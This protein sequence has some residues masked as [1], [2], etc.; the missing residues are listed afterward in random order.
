M[1]KPTR[2]TKDLF[3]TLSEKERAEAIKIV[4]GRSFVV[5]SPLLQ[6]SR[7]VEFIDSAWHIDARRWS[8]VVAEGRKFQ[9][10][11]VDAPTWA[12]G[13]S[14]NFEAALRN[15]EALREALTS[16]GE[17]IAVD[18][19][20]S[21]ISLV[22]AA[23]YS[24]ALRALGVLRKQ[25]AKLELPTPALD[26]G[27][28]S[29]QMAA[30]DGDWDA[31]RLLALISRLVPGAFRPDTPPNFTV[32]NVPLLR[33][34][35][36]WILLGTQAA[37]ACTQRNGWVKHRLWQHME[38]VQHRL[39]EHQRA[40]IAR[41]NDRDVGASS[42]HFLIMDTGHGK[43]VTSL[44][45]AHRWLSEHGHS[46]R[47]ILWIT[48][49][50]TVT[51]LT[52]Q[53][54]ETWAVP[55]FEVPRLSSAKTVKEGNTSSLILKDFHV[56]VIHAD[57]LRTAISKGLAEEAAFS[58]IIFDEVDEMYA[59]TL[60][61]S[62]ARRLCQL[63]PKFVAQ[64]AT[65]LR[66]NESQLITWL[67]DTCAFP[68][69]HVNWL[70]A[71]SGMVSIQLEL[72]IASIEE[73]VLIPMNDEVRKTCTVLHKSRSWLDM[74]RVVQ[75]ATDD[76]MCKLAVS[77]ASKDRTK[78][79]Q[80]GVLL[81]ADNLQHAEHLIALC[82][83]RGSKVGG[84]SCLE[85]ADTEKYEIV[86][87]T[88]H[89]DRGYN[90]AVRL[91]AMVTGAYAGNGSARHQIRGRLRRMGQKR[92][93]V[94]FVTVVMENSLLHLLH[95]RHSMVDCMNISLEQLGQQFCAEVLNGLKK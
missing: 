53:L 70:V 31:Y 37:Q 16:E 89:N 28:G 72:G 93:E 17:G 87:V 71:A 67:S 44:V 48:P 77:L 4:R 90:S 5:T 92:D 9:V 85:V 91:G 58:F 25:C 42:G 65:P 84:F 41:M 30:Y 27:L 22:R 94:R 80:G 23:K 18:A 49:A 66:R 24:V 57:H 13:T 43:T 33:V 21:I 2:A 83:K 88:K 19:Q 12:R 79:K 10:P 69:T 1:L 86:V 3:K 8:D 74:A 82:S 50:G 56:N 62:A 39:M 38:G 75:A 60:R 7:K 11:I 29:D 61:T 47:R 35:E 45:Y 76:A 34:L 73:D 46:V 32:S 55:V 68:V 63:C 36:G 54:E 81:V 78:H 6:G 15:D 51:N 14:P 26:G 40:A 95:Q 59:P 52:K 64:T 20:Q